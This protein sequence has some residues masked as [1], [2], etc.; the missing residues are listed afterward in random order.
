M[1]MRRQ[2]V[3]GHGDDVFYDGLILR[4]DPAVGC[5]TGRWRFRNTVSLVN[6]S[7]YVR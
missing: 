4:V 1:G 7:G 6:V 5:D 2:R 3:S